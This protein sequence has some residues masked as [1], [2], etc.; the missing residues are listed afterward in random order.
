MLIRPHGWRCCEHTALLDPT[1]LN[2]HVL[3]GVFREEPA[4]LQA[5]GSNQWSPALRNMGAGPA[6]PQEGNGARIATLFS[7]IHLTDQE[8]TEINA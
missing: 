4:D 5:G 2:I 7:V 1:P 6:G 8:M 3:D